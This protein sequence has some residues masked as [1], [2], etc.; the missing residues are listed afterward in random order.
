MRGAVTVREAAPPAPAQS[1]PRAWPFAAYSREEGLLHGLPAELKLLVFAR[2]DANELGA[3]SCTGHDLR[4][5]TEGL[6]AT[7]FE[8]RWATS[9]VSACNCFAATSGGHAG[10]GCGGVKWPALHG[11]MEAAERAFLSDLPLRWQT[12]PGRLPCEEGHVLQADIAVS[13]SLAAAVC[14]GSAFNTLHVWRGEVAPTPVDVV[15]VWHL[16]TATLLP[17]IVL[18]S[19]P[20]GQHAPVVRVH[21]DSLFL[22]EAGGVSVRAWAY[23]AAGSEPAR[24]LVGHTAAVKAMS[25]DDRLVA[26]GSSDC[27]ARVW[28]RHSG[29]QRLALAHAGA[30]LEVQLVQSR[31]AA[32]SLRP[33]GGSSTTVWDA[34]TGAPVATLDAWAC[35]S[36]RGDRIYAQGD[37]WLAALGARA[38]REEVRFAHSR[39]RTA[40]SSALAVSDAY[41]LSAVT[42]DDSEEDGWVVAAWRAA[43]GCF[44]GYLGPHPWEVECAA[45]VGDVAVCAGLDAEPACLLAWDLS[46]LAGGVAAPPSRLQ[47]DNPVLALGLAGPRLVVALSDGQVRS[48]DLG[49]CPAGKTRAAAD[50]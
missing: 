24:E 33:G 48:A 39:E 1:V 46:K 36:P 49:R 18:P 26:T 17:P 10:A 13:R 28:D 22:A 32:Q 12:L 34:V 19:D 30:V 3:L 35:L 27:T 37:G 41:V 16:P 4:R 21:G 8:R 45:L 23:G 11:Q 43:D 25:V 2:L 38:G 14:S 42:D 20:A 9:R 29:A 7:V 5:Q 6:W 50:A 31:L 40:A 44:L 47:L 15:V